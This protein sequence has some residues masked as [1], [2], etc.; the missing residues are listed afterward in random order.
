MAA[1]PR[2]RAG[3]RHGPPQ[4]SMRLLYKAVS[5]VDHLAIVIG[6]VAMEPPAFHQVLFSNPFRERTAGAIIAVLE[7]QNIPTACRTTAILIAADRFWSPQLA[8][9]GFAAGWRSEL[10]GDWKPEVQAL[11][12]RPVD[13]Q[14][15]LEGG[16]PASCRS[17]PNYRL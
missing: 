11:D 2:R 8:S 15:R 5:F 10:R 4:P 3:N 1:K 14:R 17:A 6:T 16:Q 7:Q 12:G 9:K 13:Y